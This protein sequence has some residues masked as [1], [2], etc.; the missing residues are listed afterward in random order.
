MKKASRKRIGI[1]VVSALVI[2]AIVATVILLLL[3]K[4]QSQVEINSFQQCASAGYP[5]QQSFPEVCSVPN[6][7]SFTNN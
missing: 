1:I 4:P 2:I 7:K 5:I 6:G 3:P